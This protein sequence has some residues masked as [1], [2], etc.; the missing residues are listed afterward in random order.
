MI[1]ARELR[2]E[3]GNRWTIHL[4]LLVEAIAVAVA[5]PGLR[6]TVAGAWTGKLEVRASFRCAE[7]ALVGA[8]AAVIFGIALPSCGDAAIIGASELISAAGHIR[9]THLIAIITAIVLGIAVECHWYATTGFALELVCAARRFCAVLHFVAVV[10]AVIF[11][12]AHPGFWD[13]SGN[14]SIKS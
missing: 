14:R 1:R 11:A 10:E 7:L 6:Y 9:T 8:V 5:H 4:V 13:T 3:T 12:I 2:T